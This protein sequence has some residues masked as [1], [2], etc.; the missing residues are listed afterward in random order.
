MPPTSPVSP[1]ANEHSAFNNALAHSLKECGAI[2]SSTPLSAQEPDWFTPTQERPYGYQAQTYTSVPGFTPQ[3]ITRSPPASETRPLMLNVSQPES[4]TRSLGSR[5]GYAPQSPASLTSPL[6]SPVQSM[7]PFR[8]VIASPPASMNSRPLLSSAR[9]T[10]VSESGSPKPRA[11]APHV[12]G[13]FPWAASVPAGTARALAHQPQPVSPIGG[14]RT[15]TRPV[16]GAQPFVP[17]HAPESPIAGPSSA[18]F[19]TPT[20]QN[21]APPRTQRLITPPARSASKGSPLPAPQPVAPAVQLLSQNTMTMFNTFSDSD[22]HTSPTSMS[23]EQHDIDPWR[24]LHP[25]GRAGSKPLRFEREQAVDGAMRQRLPMHS[26]VVSTESRRQAGVA[27]HKSLV[28]I[29]AG[30]S[31]GAFETS[32]DQRRF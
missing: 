11:P 10:L 31:G 8:S 13:P 3:S 20:K 16:V 2:R 1:L 5:R 24:P 18:G 27:V 9:P 7:D 22:G 17:S 30:S 29:V 19:F 14:P 28:R 4:P 26:E 15:P 32:G 23:Q 12:P 6:G 25:L 21:L